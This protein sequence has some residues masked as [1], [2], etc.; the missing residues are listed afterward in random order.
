MIFNPK[1]SVMRA[2][3]HNV[4]LTVHP[5]EGAAF[6]VAADDAV[7][8]VL[9]AT[10]AALVAT[11]ATD[12]RAAAD[13]IAAAA[14]AHYGDHQPEIMGQAVASFGEWLAARFPRH[15]LTVREGIL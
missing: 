14:R 15:R 9:E 1:G 2:E 12:G 11:V 6:H 7:S 5:T 4:M 13:G 10:G 8:A 3:T